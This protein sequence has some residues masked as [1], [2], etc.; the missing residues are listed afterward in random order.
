MLRLVRGRNRGSRI[1]LLVFSEGAL[2][3]MPTGV[4][5]AAHCLVL[6]GRLG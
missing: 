1:R 3:N 4:F 6:N 2:R 5:R